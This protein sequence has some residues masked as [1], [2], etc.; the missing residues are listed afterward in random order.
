[1]GTSPQHT[2][3][4]VFIAPFHEPGQDPTLALERDLELIQHVDRLGFHEAWVGEHHSTGWETI[5]SPELFLAVA[6][7]RT[8]H[9]RLG[10]GAVSLPYHHPLM[11]ADR[12]CLLDHLTRG[13]INLGVGPGGHLT[14]AVMLGLDINELRPQMAEALDVEVTATPAWRVGTLTITGLHSLSQFQ[15]WT[16]RIL[17]IDGSRRPADP[18]R[19][20]R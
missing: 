1:M 6:A 4:G 20:Q 15:R 3:F 5:A 19:D 2:R 16:G 8:K 7:E 13:R 14:D 11:V 12:I 10:T 9:I 18:E 17:G